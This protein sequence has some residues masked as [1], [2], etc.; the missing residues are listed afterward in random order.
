M[1]TYYAVEIKPDAIAEL[2]FRELPHPEF[3]VDEHLRYQQMA[4]PEAIGLMSEFEVGR[5]FGM[6]ALLEDPYPALVIYNTTDDH[7]LRALLSWSIESYNEDTKGKLVR[8][9]VDTATTLT[10]LYY[11]YQSGDGGFLRQTLG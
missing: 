5:L 6:H 8:A 7:R 1:T 9:P 2:L 10:I 11:S 3:P 4:Y